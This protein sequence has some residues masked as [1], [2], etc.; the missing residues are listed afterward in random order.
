MTDT[1][2]RY[3]TLTD[4]GQQARD[5]AAKLAEF[6]RG[7]RSSLDI[8]VYDF[9]LS[10]DVAAPIVA[11][12]RDATAHGVAVRFAYNA[13]HARPIAVPPPPRTDASLITRCAVPAKAI[14][15]IPHLMHHKYVVRD[16]SDVWTGSTNWTDDSWTREENLILT[17]SAPEVA[18]AYSADFDDLWQHGVVENSGSSAG[19][20]N[21]AVRPWF[22][23]AD[24]KHLAHRIATALG[25]A[26]RIRLASPVI[27]AA[28]IL[29]T[30]AEIAAERRADLAGVFDATQMNE[31][32]GQWR[33]QPEAR[34][35]IGAF[36][37]VARLAQFGGK[38]STPYAPGSTHDYMHAKIVV[39][40]DL[41]FAG[42][43][44]LSHSGE[45]NAE[46]VLEIRDPDLAR[47]M[48]SFIDSV[49]SRYPSPTLRF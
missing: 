49:R 15:G 32:F 37:S 6:L 29:A 34:W 36:R 40:D 13:S 18:H 23:P 39:A 2:V 24:G 4:G 38:N 33:E 48:A 8:A 20:V 3:T 7:A 26:S 27:T 42:S 17:L 31:V 19:H 47:E 22:S 43:Y 12:L 28:P 5:V 14:P 25:R 9:S 30:L 11:A 46:N 21:G 41:V 44:N 1:G 45:E 16:R 10:D 35:K